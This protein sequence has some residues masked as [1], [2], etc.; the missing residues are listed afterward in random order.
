MKQLL[1]YEQLQTYNHFDGIGQHNCD[2]Q[3]V[4]ED[5]SA[6]YDFTMLAINARATSKL[7]SIPP[8]VSKTPD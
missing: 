4:A 3:R 1:F 7:A 8:F 2:W 6:G 5:K